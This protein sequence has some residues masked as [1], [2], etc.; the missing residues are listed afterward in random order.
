MMAKRH[1]ED[2]TIEI[3]E[4]NEDVLTDVITA[5]G[6]YTPTEGSWSGEWN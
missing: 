4:M 2:P 3:V 6:D 1:Y 5:S